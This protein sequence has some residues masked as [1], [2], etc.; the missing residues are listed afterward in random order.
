M[1]IIT[2]HDILDTLSL[3]HDNAESTLHDSHCI[4]LC[5]KKNTLGQKQSQLIQIINTSGGRWAWLAHICSFRSADK[6]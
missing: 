2:I 6:Y 1:I 4:N 5:C 3:L